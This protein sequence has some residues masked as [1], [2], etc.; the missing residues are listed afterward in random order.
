MFGFSSDTVIIGASIFFSF[1]AVIFLVTMLFRILSAQDKIYQ[2]IRNGTGDLV[3]AGNRLHSMYSLAENLITQ[4]KTSASAASIPD[5]AIEAVAD[6]SEE[7]LSEKLRKFEGIAS[8]MRGLM[9]SMLTAAPDKL[10]PWRESNSQSINK[11]LAEQHE[12]VP[13]I[14][15]LQRCLDK[16][17]IDLKRANHLAV[18]ENESN[19]ELK[20]KIET[21]QTMVIKARER[22][23]AAETTAAALQSEVNLLNKKNER[24]SI[25]NSSIGA[26]LEEEMAK[27]RSENAVLLR[28]IEDLN[29]EI[30]RT[31]IEKNFIE[32]KFIELS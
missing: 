11:L 5:Q 3:Q 28:K 22:S 1:S 6:I 20:K 10:T 4:I 8:D 21:Y 29:G 16:M 15:K 17:A 7:L 32:D 18:S 24:L 23:K 27:I 30:S 14:A 13:D 19:E 12:L 31:N 2:E 9:N 26:K 25:E